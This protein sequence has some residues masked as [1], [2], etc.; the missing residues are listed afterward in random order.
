MTSSA[1]SSARIVMAHY[2]PGLGAVDSWSDVKP[3][4]WG[5]IALFVGTG[6][7]AV[8]VIAVMDRSRP[9]RA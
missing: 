4:V 3:A 1:R 7:L 2:R 5:G 9:H 8:G 6:L